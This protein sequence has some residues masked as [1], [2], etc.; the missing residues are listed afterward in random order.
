MNPGFPAVQAGLV[1][2]SGYGGVHLTAL[3]ELVA[4]KEV[5]IVAATVINQEAEP[6]KCKA[7]REAG[8]HLYD[9]YGQMLEKE[10]GRLELCFVPTGIAWH[11]PITMAALQAGCHVLVEKPA[12]ATVRE[13]DE[14]I[15]ERDRAGR[16]VAVGFHHLYHEDYQAVKRLVLEGEIGQL[17]EIRVRAAWPRP[18]GYYR[19]NNW[20][21]RLRADGRWV[22]DS[23]ANNAFAHFLL[24]ALHL[25]GPTMH[26]TAAPLR[27]EAE[28]YRTQ[29]IETFDTIAARVFTDIGV[30]IVFA[31]THCSA[32]KEDPVI[33]LLGEYGN[34][35]WEVESALTLRP[36]SHATRHIELQP[37]AKTVIFRRVLEQIRGLAPEW[38][39]LEDA[40][41]HTLVIDA[42]HRAIPIHDIPPEHRSTLEGSTGIQHFIPGINE[43]LTRVSREG[44]LFSELGAP[45]ARGAKSALIEETLIPIAFPAS[46]SPY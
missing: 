9:D 10:S 35:R 30:E 43:L 40:R 39:R 12:A 27:L 14:M 23:P 21:G 41:K 45:W 38:C 1:G 11:G 2:V 44:L 7:L 18:S 32:E 36:S 34:L 3:R 37:N 15:L 42:L 31:V 13:I 28:L 25:A 22:L 5:R 33:D 29:E 4:Q 26:E 24:A 46:L 16:Q 17:R 19:R 6:T 8:C 20:A